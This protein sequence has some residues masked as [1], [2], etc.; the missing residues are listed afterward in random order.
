MIS[1]NLVALGSSVLSDGWC[2]TAS[3]RATR[4]LGTS[5]YDRLIGQ[6]EMRRADRTAMCT[7]LAR[8]CAASW[9]GWDAILVHRACYSAGELNGPTPHRDY[10]RLPTERPRSSLF[11]WHAAIVM[12]AMLKRAM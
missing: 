11:L 8:L 4:L 12:P 7:R 2:R 10:R 9:G 5:I 6:S 1:E 3:T